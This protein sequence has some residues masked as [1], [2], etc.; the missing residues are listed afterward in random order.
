MTQRISTKNN[1][2]SFVWIRVCACLFIVLLHTLFA[3][4][5]YFEKTITEGQLLATQTVEHLLMWAVPC[6]LMVTGALLLQPARQ[7]GP[8]K[9]FGKYMKRIALALVCFTLLFQ[10]LDVVM[11]DESS[12]LT[13]WLSDLFQ[14][15]SWA[16]VWYLYLMLGI[17]LMIPFYKMIANQ[18]DLKQIWALILIMVLFV[19]VLPR[20]AL[21]GLECGFYIPTQIIYPVYVFA[22]FALYERNLPLW[23]AALM[24]A[25]ATAVIVVLSITVPGKEE[26]FGYD[27][28]FVVAQSLGLF[29]LMLRIKLP[30]GGFL[31]SLDDCGFGIYMIHMIGVRFV[32][33]W[34]GFDP[35]AHGPVICFAVMVLLFFAV[36]YA[37]AYLLRQIPKLNLL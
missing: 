8:G 1:I 30:A 22:G 12:I 26:F 6:F 34:V 29:S 15:H 5:V 37:V 35:F 25:A 11:G 24:A 14:G 9:L 2:T 10:I 28:I 18:A 19:S 3:S 7:I 27:S 32:M 31:Q 21:A 33:K 20:A 4:N 13:G 36:S 17:Y 23:A 16:H